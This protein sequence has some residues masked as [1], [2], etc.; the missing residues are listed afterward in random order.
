[1]MD[2]LQ[3]L[4]YW[5]WFVF[6]FIF[7]GLELIIPGSFFFLSLAVGALLTGIVGAFWSVFDWSYQTIFFAIISVVSIFILRKVLHY[8]ETA[9]SKDDLN[10][11]EASLIGQVYPLVEPIVNGRGRVKIG[12][13]TWSVEG[14]NLESGKMVKIIAAKGSILVVIKHKDD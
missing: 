11:R 7:S 8:K 3:N 14:P 5:H 1:M 4:D 12:D 13:T 6:T 10:Q 9:P 2:F